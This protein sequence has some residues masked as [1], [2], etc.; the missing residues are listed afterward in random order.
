M[1][2]IWGLV[3]GINLS[4]CRTCIGGTGAS[5]IGTNM[6]GAGIAMAISFGL[7]ILLIIGTLAFSEKF[8]AVSLKYMALTV[9]IPLVS[10]LHDFAATSWGWP[11]P[12]A[13]IF[14]LG[15]VI[16]AIILVWAIATYAHVVNDES[17]PFYRNDETSRTAYALLG[18]S[19]LIGALGSMIVEWASGINDGENGAIV[20]LSISGG[21]W[22]VLGILYYC[23]AVIPDDV[24]GSIL[25]DED[26]LDETA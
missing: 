23:F 12:W 3:A 26:E 10:I 16:A 1:L 25:K 11:T 8:G 4:A 24:D 15:L 7:V 20:L 21:L 2:A 5:P 6:V 19:A 14:Y 13:Q 17:D 18:G 9:P 22:I